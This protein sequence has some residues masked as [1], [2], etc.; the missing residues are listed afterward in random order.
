MVSPISASPS[1]SGM[2]AAQ[3]RISVSANNIA[4]TQ[5]NEFYRQEVIQQTN[6]NGGVT[7]QVI[8]TPQPGNALEKDM[9]EQL[10]AK[11]EFLANLQV[12]KSQNKMLGSL[13]DLK[14]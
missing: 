1:V 12:F 13:V 3:T 2:Q 8:K 5:T 6:P 11:N 10:A 9:V 4:N 7:A 14:A